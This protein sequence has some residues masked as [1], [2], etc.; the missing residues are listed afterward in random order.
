MRRMGLRRI[1]L[2]GL[3][4]ILILR[5]NDLAELGL[6]RV[7]DFVEYWS[8]ARLHVSGENPYSH[9]EL[10]V[11]QRSAGWRGA[12]PLPMYNPPWTLCLTLPLGFFPY[13]TARVLWLFLNVGSVV[14]AVDWASYHYGNLLT[15]KPLYWGLSALFLPALMAVQ[16]GQISPLL[17]LG[18]V[19]F[20]SCERQQ[21]GVMAGAALVMLAIKP[22]LFYLVWLA[23]VFWTLRWRRWDV[24]AGT[25]LAI[26]GATSVALSFNPA[27]LVQYASMIQSH[28]P[29]LL[30]LTPTLGTLL[31]LHL[32]PAKFWLQFVPMLAGIV[33]FLFHWRR[34]QSTWAWS[35]EMPIL[36]L[37]S[38]ATTSFAWMFD[39]VVLL[40]FIMQALGWVLASRKDRLKVLALTGYTLTSGFLLIL[41]AFKTEH[42]YY[43][44]LA[45][46]WLAGYLFLRVYARPMPN[47]PT[48]ARTRDCSL[49]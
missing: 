29:P 38:M 46:V 43:V 20:L 16:M 45:P 47:E 32:G 26:L 19:G 10:L 14:F 24:M 36:L 13:F 15:A 40:P 34:R 49:G 35:E 1:V 33:W 5:A 37:V 25:G 23:F 11:V 31:R 41:I 22:H 21:R 44:W 42:S 17:L 8:A 7:D 4:F 12:L 30:W 28:A 39:Q 2:F 9:D 18:V 6:L 48:S 27:I 3:G